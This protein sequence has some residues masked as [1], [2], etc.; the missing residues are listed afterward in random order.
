MLCP[1]H[2]LAPPSSCSG[3]ALLAQA[4][5]FF[6]GL[7]LAFDL[8]WP[9][10][11]SWRQFTYQYSNYSFRQTRLCLFPSFLDTILALHAS[12]DTDSQ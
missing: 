3:A 6:R 10:V 4:F 9:A 11:W 7:T 2:T 1:E 8:S 5:C 12:N